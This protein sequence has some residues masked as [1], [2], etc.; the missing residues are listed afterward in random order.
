MKRTNARLLQTLDHEYNDG[1]ISPPSHK[2]Q[3]YLQA[4][5]K[6]SIALRSNFTPKSAGQ[7]Y[8]LSLLNECSITFCAGP[9]GTGKTWIVTRFALE[10]LLNHNVSK[11]VVTKPILEAGEEEIGFLPGDV[12]DKIL[13][14]FQSVLDCIEDHIGPTMTKKLLDSH[15]IEFLPT[16]YCRGRNLKN[17]YILI[18][19]AQ[20][21]TR[22]GIKL[23]LTRI[24]EGSL[25]ALNGDT[26]QTDLPNPQDSGFEWAL[27]CLAGK[28]PSIG[29]AEL[30]YGDIQRHPL[31]ETILTNLR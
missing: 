29:V 31:I 26:D 6:E 27:N 1:I 17:A 16:A 11:I 19:E 23:L 25:M 30:D 14:H 13:P 12:A 2:R 18:D 3:K 5:K 4:V 9:A 22:K 28:S 8:Y 7:E 15:Q 10:Q 21:L 24:A 20:N